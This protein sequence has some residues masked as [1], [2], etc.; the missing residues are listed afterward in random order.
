MSN[1]SDSSISTP[2]LKISEIF[3]SL[4]GE[5]SRSGLPTVFIRLAGCP[6]RCRWCD[7]EYAF[8]GGAWTTAA[9]ILAAVRVY[10]T[11]HVCVTGGEPLAQADCLTLLAMLADAGYEVCLET[12][13]ALPIHA[14][15]ARV[16]R[17]VDLKAPSSGEAAKNHWDNLAQ[18]TA[19]DEVK[20]IIA[21]REDYEWASVILREKLAA[22]ASPIWFSPAYNR[23]DAR[24]LA[25]WI[26]ADGLPVRLQIQLHKALWGNMRGR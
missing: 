15:D 7:T 1:A 11:R 16:A 12:S 17:I 14:V 9:E 2:S 18:I 19:R 4:Q 13:G 23:Q 6:L 8:T 22:L 5:A 3:F 26:L 24:E 21:D 10:P 25:E 20:I